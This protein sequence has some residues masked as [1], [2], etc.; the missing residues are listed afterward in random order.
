MLPDLDI[1]ARF[2]AM[3]SAFSGVFFYIFHKPP[4]A[5]P[6]GGGGEHNLF[7]RDRLF[8]ADFTSFSFLHAG[9]MK[10]FSVKGLSSSLY[11]THFNFPPPFHPYLPPPSPFKH[12]YSSSSS[13]TAAMQCFLWGLFF[14]LYNWHTLIPL[15]LPSLPP[16]YPPGCPSTSPEVFLLPPQ[17]KWRCFLWGLVFFLYNWH[18]LILLYPSLFTPI[19]PPP[20]PVAP[21][22][23]LK[24]SCFLHSKNDDVFWG[25]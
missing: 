25:D 8:L 13:C 4:P 1:E 15:T 22:L 16:Y 5:F 12:F 19:L 24:Y 18:T 14:F 10:I 7:Y 23:L 11:L 21:P 17:Q 20:S 2:A 9:V 3:F 6:G